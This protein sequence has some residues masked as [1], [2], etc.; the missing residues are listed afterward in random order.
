MEKQCFQE[1]A[2]LQLKVKK[3]GGLQRFNLHNI[4]QE[5]KRSEERRVGK[6]C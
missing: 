2:I 3:H 6:E 5:R 1:I 4:C